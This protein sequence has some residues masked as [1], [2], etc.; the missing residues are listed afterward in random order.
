MQARWLQKSYF[1]HRNDMLGTLVFTSSEYW[2]SFSFFRAQSYVL[3][4]VLFSNL[5]CFILMTY[6]N[7]IIFKTSRKKKLT[8]DKTELNHNIQW[9]PL[10]NLLQSFIHNYDNTDSTINSSLQGRLSALGKPKSNPV[11]QVSFYS[12]KVNKNGTI[13][14]HDKKDENK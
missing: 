12:G 6:S 13:S 9:C 8:K 5:L 2:A 1:F 3:V 10:I 7:I 14:E 11:Q 4:V